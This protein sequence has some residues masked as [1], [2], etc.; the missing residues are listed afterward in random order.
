MKFEKKLARIDAILTKFDGSDLPLDESVELYKEGLDL[1][2]DCSE[3]LSAAKKLAD[4]AGKNAPPTD[5][6]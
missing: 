3:Q 6:K 4:E 2:S 1:I 5:E